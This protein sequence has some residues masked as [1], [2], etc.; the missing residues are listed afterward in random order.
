MPVG[1][2][3]TPISFVA[4]PMLRISGWFDPLMKRPGWFDQE[5][6]TP[7]T[8]AAVHDL[9][10]SR[11]VFYINSASRRQRPTPDDDAKKKHRKLAEQ[12]ARAF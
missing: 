2:P 6:A 9:R 1:A 3:A 12:M 11:T 8:A 4:D 5:Y 7:A 10:G